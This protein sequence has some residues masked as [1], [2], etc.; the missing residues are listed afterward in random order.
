[1]MDRVQADATRPGPLSSFWS[2]CPLGT[3]CSFAGVLLLSLGLPLAGCFNPDGALSADAGGSSSDGASS[4]GGAE[5][6]EGT[7]STAEPS[8]SSSTTTLTGET[9][10]TTDDEPETSSTTTAADDDTTTSSDTSTGEPAVLCDAD[11]FVASGECVACPEGATNEAGDDVEGPDTVCDDACSEVLGVTC[12]VYEQGYFKASNTDADDSFGY[13]VA[14]SGDTLAVGAPFEASAS[15]GVNPDGEDDN[16]AVE[17]GAVYVFRRVDGAWSQEAYVKADNAQ[18][19]DAFGESLALFEDTLVVGAP[20]EDSG[21][22]GVSLEGSGNNAAG[23]AGAVYVFTRSGTTWSQ[24]AYVKASNA[25]V[26]DRFGTSVALWED[27]L[28]VG[29][30][31]EDGEGDNVVSSAGAAYVFQR[32]GVT[33]VQE[34]YL[35]ASNPD[36]S[37]DFGVSIALWG[38]TLAVGA[39]R[40]DSGAV[41]V[42][43]EGED[44]NTATSSGAVYVFERTDGAWSQAAYVKASN[45]EATDRFGTSIALTAD[46]LAIGA[47]GEDSSATGV[48][49]DETDNSL[50]S[51]GA[52]YVFTRVD[53]TWNQQAYIK[54]SNTGANDA[55]G[56]SL[57]LSGDTLA[58]GAQFEDSASTGLNGDGA[59]DFASIAGATYVFRR[60]GVAW[61]SLAY[62][63]AVNANAGD[64]FG[65][66][67]ALSGGLLASGAWREDGDA[68]GIGGDATDN[69]A[70]DAGAAYVYQI[71]P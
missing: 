59:N 9:S 37:D 16:S 40:E 52:V 42:N 32:V 44:D 14:L 27:T 68:T 63:K 36:V 6:S 28:A 7:S 67:V 22:S 21:T 33:W 12:D 55:F 26:S 4:T 53:G 65:S 3:G 15:L 17:A 31:N 2:I 49:G 10:S 18:G 29:A 8:T 19:G 35:K 51:S 13:A 56:V 46:T 41:G 66:A 64:T 71:A 54:A 34:A 20:G 30:R 39:D 62:I 24:E 47:E 69:S 23:G 1:M 48:D 38:D 25:D 60:E 11:Q 58:V 43:A 70:D 5:T 50:S 45:T 57:A 61:S